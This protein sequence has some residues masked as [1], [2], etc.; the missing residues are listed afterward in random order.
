MDLALFRPRYEVKYRE[1]II[2]KFSEARGSISNRPIF[3]Q[4][5]QCYAWAAMLGFIHDRHRP[6]ESKTDV[7]FSLGTINTHGPL[8]YNALICSALAKAEQGIEILR[9][10]KGIVTIIEEYTNG[11][12]DYISELIEEKGVA[13]FDDFNNILMEVVSRPE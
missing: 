11:G 4:L 8:V 6:L 7:A 2:N 13:H 1:S 12:F 9:D 5:W 3:S 10:P